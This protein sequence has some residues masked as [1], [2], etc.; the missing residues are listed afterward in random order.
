MAPLAYAAREAV[1]HPGSRGGR[2]PAAGP[3][4]V[5][6]ERGGGIVNWWIVSAV[7]RSLRSLPHSFEG[8]VTMA[9]TAS[10]TEPSDAPDRTSP[11]LVPSLT[12]SRGSFTAGSTTRSTVTV[13]K[14]SAWRVSH[15]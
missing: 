2:G 11:R 12:T 9:G 8:Y 1:R 6:R 10:R 5:S 14:R 4:R 7:S 15:S 13:R 3:G